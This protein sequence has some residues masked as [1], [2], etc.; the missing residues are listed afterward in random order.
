M[1]SRIHKRFCL[2]LAGLCLLSAG[3]IKIRLTVKLNEDG[4]GQVIEDIVFSERIVDASKRLADVPTI[5]ELTSDSQIQERVAHMGQG[6]RFAGKKVE[7][8]PDGSVRL[9]VTYAFD[10]ISN[11]KL[12][13]IP[14]GEG[15]E[16]V[17]MSFNLR[18]DTTLNADYHLDIR[19]H[20]A[21]GKTRSNQQRPELPR[22]TEQETQQIRQLLPV[23]RDLLEGFEL[24]LRLELFDEKQWA[25]TTKGHLATG[26]P[27]GISVAGGRQTIYHLTDQHLRAGDDGLMVLVP[28]RQVGREF[29]LEK[30]VHAWTGKQLLP[31]VHYFLYGD[32]MEFQWRAIQTPRGREYY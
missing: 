2:V 31:H 24:K 4:T 25:S 11:L 14:F 9:L 17:H 12:A 15:W 8:L 32:R 3:C 19:Y 29:D 26:G 5:E 23:F 1:T 13:P 22:L 30:G 20:T 10:D 21:E 18:A 27:N 6:V 7:N 28:W 16:N